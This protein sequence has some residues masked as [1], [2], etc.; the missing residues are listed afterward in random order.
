MNFL[1]LRSLLIG[2][3]LV[4]VGLAFNSQSNSALAEEDHAG[5]DHGHKHEETDQ[6]DR[7]QEKDEHA[8][9]QDD[10]QDHDDHDDHSD[11]HGEEGG[12]AGHVEA[13]AIEWNAELLEAS[14]ITLAVAG[15]GTIKV[16]LE[17]PG[18]IVSYEANVA[19]I[20]PR[21]PGIIREVNKRL[22]DPVKKDDVLAVIES[23]QS[24]SLYKVLS[25]IDGVILKRHST[26]GEYAPE[27]EDIF[28]VADLS[29]VWGEFYVFPE[30]FSAVRTG[31]PISVSL[32]SLPMPIESSISFVSGV[33]DEHTQSKLVRAVLPNSNGSLYPGAFASG[34]VT[35]ESHSANV[36]V[37]KSALQRMED[38]EAVF[39]KEGS[40]FEPRKV[41]I[42]K[43]DGEHVE[44][45]RGVAPGEQYAAGNIFLIKAELGKAEAEHAH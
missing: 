45:L 39:V 25:P 15:P 29:E 32:K 23:N 11:H 28:V 4:F 17:I 12:H 7:H 19:H 22:G 18:K 34:L 35:L 24:L 2:S 40:S 6:R 3:C 42:G 37:K 30:N 21:F 10:H 26:V 33:V 44:I 36:V 8:K 27:N 31:L 5:H 20:I 1:Q 38:G 13:V 41:S 16:G 43:R 14:G 9:H